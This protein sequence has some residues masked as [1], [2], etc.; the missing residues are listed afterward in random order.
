MSL[1]SYTATKRLAIFEDLRKGLP[2]QEGEFDPTVLEEARK[3]GEVQMGSTHYDPWAIYVEYIFPDPGSTATVLSVKLKAPERIV[4]LPVPEWVVE[5]IWQ[6]DVQGTFHL[7]SE[8]RRLYAAL[9]AE[10]ETEQN[11]KWFG[12]QMAKR[13]E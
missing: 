13:R 10:L 3:K 9:G 2:P 8:A 11:Q 7:E 5:N 6:G 12:P 1:N 4:F